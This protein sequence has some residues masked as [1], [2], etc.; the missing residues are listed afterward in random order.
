MGIVRKKGFTS[1]MVNTG[2]DVIRL[3]F[4]NTVTFLALL[5]GFLKENAL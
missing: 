1:H 4:L 3:C 2:K 5:H